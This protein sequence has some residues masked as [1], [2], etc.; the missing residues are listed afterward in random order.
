MVRR[1]QLIVQCALSFTPTNF[2]N[3]F[4]H[5]AA[6][7]NRRTD[8]EDQ[9][10]KGKGKKRFPAGHYGESLVDDCSPYSKLPPH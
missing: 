7:Q 1:T 2:E 3:S 5:T 4:T 6:A 9:I 8:D 10:H